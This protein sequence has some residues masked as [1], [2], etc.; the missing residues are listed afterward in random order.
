MIIMKQLISLCIIL[1]QMPIW[2]QQW[3]LR[4]NQ[5]GIKVWTRNENGKI[6][7]KAQTFVNASVRDVLSLIEK[8][9]TYHLWVDMVS[10][11]KLLSYGNE[12]FTVWYLIDMPW[13]FS[14]RDFV[15]DNILAHNG[16]TIIV[17]L[18]SAPDRY[19]K[20]KNIVRVQDAYGKWILFPYGKRTFVSYQFYADMQLPV[21]NSLI[22][23]LSVSAPFNTFQNLKT[24]LNHKK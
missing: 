9:S 16:D 20:Q 3:V 23:I 12:K 4:E 14:D 11:A 18:K 1:L 17:K 15:L 8:P 13:L 10:K 6:E 5:Q 24:M 2:A 19:P 22:E 7:V 21:S